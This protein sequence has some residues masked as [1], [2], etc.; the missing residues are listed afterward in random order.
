MA[1]VLRSDEPQRELAGETAPW[2]SEIH[3]RCISESGP[4]IPSGFTSGGIG[5]IILGMPA[6]TRR[7]DPDAH[8]ETWL[9]YYGD[10]HAGTIMRCVGNP[11]MAPQWQWRCGFYPGS[12][13]GEGKS[14]TA[15]SFEAARAAFLAAWRVFLSN[16]TEA[17][18]QEWRD[19]RDWTARKYALWGAGERLPS[20]RPSSMMR[21]ICGKTF[22]SH[23]LEESL[24]HVPPSERSPDAAARKLVEI[25]NAVEAVQDGG[26]TSSLSM[27]HSARPVARRT[28]SAPAS[29]APLHRAGSGCMN[30]EPM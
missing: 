21:C 8:Q 1:S 23:W 29:N 9:V 22:D 5:G 20:Q 25:A 24:I 7:R 6:L 18:F 19:Q 28:S 10:V 12:E 30:Q 27:P 16:R 26:F 4:T 13:P 11:N 14:G 15:P 17:D 2:P 3:D